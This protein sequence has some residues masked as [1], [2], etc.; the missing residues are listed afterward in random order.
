MEFGDIVLEQEQKALLVM[1][2]E[3]ARNVPRDQRQ[4]FWVAQAAGGDICIHAGLPG[5]SANTY[6][7]DFE[8]LANERLLNLSYSPSGTPQFDVTPL[9]FAYYD[10]LKKQTGQPAQRVE[11]SIKGHLSADEFQR[12]YSLAYKKWCEAEDLL[13]VS[14]SETQ[15][16]TIGHLCR[17][18]IQEF[19]TALVERFQPA[20][21]DDNKAHDVNRMKS[22]LQLR[23]SRLGD[24]ERS[25]LD[26]LLEY[27]KAVSS[28]VQ[29]EEH[30]GQ[31]EGRS[32]VW[33]DGR[34]VVFQTVVVMF[35]VDKAVVR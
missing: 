21:V 34:R 13:W 12:K 17:E 1:L 25:F 35:E 11:S 5:G 16:K 27:W 32:L 2:V 6:M 14:D 3:A 28:L 31:R 10:Y 26:A 8:I 7:G 9:G 20:D 33:E 30:G 19:A 29:R 24:T 23:A 22:V 4:K 18:A 15:L